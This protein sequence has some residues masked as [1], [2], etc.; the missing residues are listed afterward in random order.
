MWERAMKSYKWV[1]HLPQ[2]SVKNRQYKSI[3]EWIEAEIADQR[4]ERIRLERAAQLRY[5]KLQSRSLLQRYRDRLAFSTGS[6][7]S[8]HITPLSG[9][10]GFPSRS[11]PTT[12]GL[13]D[14]RRSDGSG[15]GYGYGGDRGRLGASGSQRDFK[16]SSLMKGKL[17]SSTNADEVPPHHRGAQ[18]SPKTQV[19]HGHSQHASSRP[20][21][22]SSPASPALTVSIPSPSLE[23][24]S[25]S[26]QPSPTGRRNIGGYS[27]EA[28]EGG[29][30]IEKSGG[31][32][33]FASRSMPKETAAAAA[34]HQRYK[35]LF[36]T[37][38]AELPAVTVVP[39]GGGDDS[40]PAGSADPQYRTADAAKAAA[41]GRGGVNVVGAGGSGGGDVGQ[42]ASYR[43]AQA[44]KMDYHNPV[45]RRSS[46]TS[47]THPVGHPG[48]LSSTVQFR[49]HPDFL[50]GW[51]GG[52]AEAAAA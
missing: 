4:K 23:R 21:G 9:N 5:Q 12:A 2:I 36:T 31:M 19:M 22:P 17:R 26:P 24:G 7:A 49:S 10:T 16:V 45:R 3:Q 37:A 47:F 52:Q 34:E 20:G 6:L 46:D 35:S 30:D 41:K 48:G 1:H 11:K 33:T 50:R 39:A 51:G 28:Y 27:S 44:V 32:G 8:V 43:R 29:G 14:G 15:Y 13:G 25:S 38:P 18:G 40:L 42:P